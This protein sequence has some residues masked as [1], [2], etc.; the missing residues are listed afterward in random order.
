MILQV[1]NTKK[2][3]HNQIRSTKATLFQD[4]KEQ[5]W[6]VKDCK[7]T[8]LKEALVNTIYRGTDGKNSLKR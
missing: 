4:L 6:A 8:E 2:E 7:V 5:G 1:I 3:K